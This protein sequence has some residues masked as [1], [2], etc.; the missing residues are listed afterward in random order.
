MW[1]EIKKSTRA[2]ERRHGKHLIWREKYIFVYVQREKRVEKR[3]IFRVAHTLYYSHWQTLS[4]TFAHHQALV[5]SLCVDLCEY[6]CSFFDDDTHIE[7]KE[8]ASTHAHKA[9]SALGIYSRYT[10][11]TS[12]LIRMVSGIAFNFSSVLFL[13]LSLC[14]IRLKIGRHVK[15]H[16]KKFHIT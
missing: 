8:S 13:S 6:H 11:H 1:I 15:K 3:T 12:V 9:I 4:S 2:R 7:N 16:I 14:H 10:F 5:L